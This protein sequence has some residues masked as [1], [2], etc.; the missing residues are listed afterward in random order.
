MKFNFGPIGFFKGWKI[1]RPGGGLFRGKKASAAVGAQECLCFNLQEQEVKLTVLASKT[2]GNRQVEQF[3]SVSSL[4]VP[5][6]EL[7]DRLR[8]IIAGFHLKRP[9]VIGLISSNVVVTRNIEIPSRDPEEINEILSLQASR[10]TPYARNEIIIDYIN[11]GIFKSVY[12]KVLFIIVP[13]N[14]VMKYY[15]LA[16]QLNLRIEKMVFA[17]EAIA[18]FFWKDTSLAN[19]RFPV[20]ILQVDSTTSEFLIVFHGAALFV[21][22]ISIGAR[23]FEAAQEGYSVRYIEELKKS[24]ETYQSENIDLMPAHIILGGATQGLEDLASSIRETFNMSVKQVSDLD[25]LPLSPKLK[26]QQTGQNVSLLSAAAPGL[27][28]DDLKVDLSSE[29]SKFNRLMIERSKQVISSGILTMVLLGLLCFLVASTIYSKAVRLQQLT[30]RYEPIKKEAQVLED[31]YARVRVIKT[32][33]A[34]RGTALEVLTEISSL[35]SSDLYLTDFK[36][37]AGKK[38]SLKGSS[39]GKPSIFTLVDEM[40]N[41]ELFK[42]VETKYIT[43]RVEEGK[44]LSDFEIIATLK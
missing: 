20:C 29:E 39:Y 28:V 1:P 6:E 31:A 38:V 2:L 27:L 5:E 42:N 19:E 24:F 30:A 44:E 21:R 10:H 8:P 25:V 14:V 9:R 13:R 22:S 16:S 40:G 11:L 32:Y 18:R 37:E 36:F 41:S 34:T 17:P 35:I 7:G 4:G 15:D 23:H 43:G 3:H 26:E 12:T 33:L